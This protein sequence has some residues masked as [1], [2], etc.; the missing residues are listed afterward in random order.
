MKPSQNSQRVLSI[1][2]LRGI[3]ILVMIFVNEAAG[4][5][6]LP[7]W[8]KHMPADADAMT[9]VDIV[10]SAFLFI[11]GM[12]IPFALHNR[13]SK[14]DNFWQLQ[15]HILFRT[16]GL[17]VLGIF[18]VN[19]EEGLHEQATGLSQSWWSLLFYVCVILI[20]NVYTFSNK[21]IKYGLQLLGIAGL[22][23]LAFIYRAG[24]DGTK[25]METHWWGILGL[26]G[27]AYL[28]ACIFYQLVKG[29]I[30]LLLFGVVICLAWYCAANTPWFRD[31][32]LPAWVASQAGN[33]AHTSIVLCGIVLSQLFFKEGEGKTK[34]YRF[35]SVFVFTVLLFMAGFLLR[36]YF[37]ISKIYATP[38]WCLYSAG[39]CCIIFSFLYW[40]IDIKKINGWLSFF[41]PAAANPLLVYIIPYILAA[42]FTILQINIF[43]WKYRYGL[44]GVLYAFVF[45]I[46]VMFIAKGLNKL[47]IRLQL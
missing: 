17:L 28:Y 10:F 32:Y 5:R 3:T 23:A 22:V 40:L 29:N 1:D 47:K 39:I 7:V 21:L 45:S 44:P 41:K 14:G 15:Q 35:I 34:S 26:I 11:V 37:G 2:A 46:A 4:I 27:W 24:E 38:S 36:P 30:A 16:A 42:L 25:R 43:P 20:W 12:S 6:D 19:A 13:L 9:F 33:M 8:M 31:E 18:M